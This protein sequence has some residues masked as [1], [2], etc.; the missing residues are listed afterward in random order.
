MHRSDELLIGRE[1]ELQILTKYIHNTIAGTGNTIF[2]SGEAGVGKTALLNALSNIKFK[3]KIVFLKGRCYPEGYTLYSPFLEA[4]KTVNLDYLFAEEK[5]PRV[6]CVYLMTHSGLLLSRQEREISKLDADIFTSMLTAVSEFVKDSMARF[7]G[8]YTDG[9]ESLNVMGYGNYRILI[10]RGKYANLA[11]IVSGR[12]NE[13]L[14]NDMKNAIAMVDLKYGDALAEWSGDLEQIGDIADF[15]TPFFSTAKY[16]GVDYVKDRPEIKRIHLFDNIRMGLNRISAE[17]PV[18]LIIEDLQWADEP[19]LALLQYLARTTKNTKI[20]IIGTYRPEE[21]VSAPDGTAHPLAYTL[22]SMQQEGL[23]IKF[24]LQRLSEKNVTLLIADCFPNNSFSDDFK[25]YIYRE[26]DGNPFFALELLSLLTENKIIFQDSGGMWCV[27]G[28]LE[29]I[30]LPSK[31]YDVIFQ[32]LSRLPQK[33]RDVLECAA[34][35]GTEFTSPPLVSLTNFNRVELLKC[36]RDAEIHYKVVHSSKEFYK[37]D[38]TKV[39]EVL[40]KSIP[41][42]LRQEYHGLIAEWLETTH[43]DNIDGVIDELAHHSY[44]AGLKNASEYLIRSAVK[45]KTKFANEE[46]LKTFKKALEV[47][48][49]D[50]QRYYIY[51]QLGELCDILGRYNESIEWYR[52]LE[53]SLPRENIGLRVTALRKLANIYEKK[54][55]F[56]AAFENCEKA[57]RTLGTLETIERGRIY[58]IIGHIYIKKG[59]YE[60]A[61]NV[62][63]DA[64]SIY[65]KFQDM[66]KDLA[67]IYNELGVIYYQT[68]DFEKAFE[69]HEKSLQIR[70]KIDD[71]LGISSS[72][73]NI[74]NVWYSK[75]YFEKALDYYEKSLHILEAIGD[76]AGVASSLGNIGVIHR[77][78][79]AIDKALECYEKCISVM[80]PLGDRPEL[81]HAYN[82]K[83]IA[84]LYKGDLEKALECYRKSIAIKE[85]IGDEA[86][87]ASCYSNIGEVLYELDHLDTALKHYNDAAVICKRIG[88]KRAL[89]DIKSGMALVYI[90]KKDLKKADECV[91]QSLAISK[92]MGVRDDLA[93]CYKILGMICTEKNDF[94][95]AVKYFENAQTIF[96]EIGAEVELAK[97]WCEY[98]KMYMK[99]DDKAS[100]ESAI[101]NFQNAC[102]IFKKYGIML[103]YNRVNNLLKERKQ[104]AK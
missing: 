66:P 76:V 89:C 8:E 1:S 72:Y 63:R 47:C 73:N 19:S 9:K 85:K 25:K 16:E 53:L 40:Y 28:A 77:R 44:Y 71:K 52:K 94:E 49:T 96:K 5:P 62:Y 51:E 101:K 102:A 87:I 81:A 38:H 65:S 26:S 27:K 2:I 30:K 36:L 3:K 48:T 68:D 6:E 93:I 104:S 21:V 64:F 97:I 83:G 78:K 23:F 41:F 98:G 12:E 92:E 46:S 42:E 82:N 4:L 61:K 31:I 60:D 70:M 15:I 35:I 43:K 54:G 32:R 18:V 75:G 56:E 39:R 99:K 24:P 45:L 74:G 90:K 55:D 69:Y 91:K 58:S 22:Q 11:A 59:K 67:Q 10:E 79:G 80:Q 34:V 33:H 100:V 37:F 17:T 84:L 57:L 29:D 50:E 20:L 86:G 13:F 7:K 88:V 14:I 103:E 95:N